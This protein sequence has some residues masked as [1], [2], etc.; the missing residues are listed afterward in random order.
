MAEK[1]QPEVKINKWDASALKNSLDDSVKDVLIGQYKYTENFSVIDGRLMIC[2]L[3]VGLAGFALGWDYFYPFPKSR[4]VLIVCVLGYFILMGILTLYSKYI[5]KGIFCIAK[6]RARGGLGPDIVWKGSSSLKRF[7]DKY[8]LTI[9]RN[10][11][12][13]TRVA[14]V[15]NFFDSKGVLVKSA[16][17]E[18]VSTMHME[19]E[20]RNQ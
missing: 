4:P 16:I 14:S 10:D 9:S 3:A 11:S 2:T 5:E 8:S 17:L 7:D 19:L 1:K 6:E 12:E 15:G 13:V 18:Q 20:K